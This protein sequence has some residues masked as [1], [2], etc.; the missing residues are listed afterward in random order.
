MTTVA[1]RID[2]VDAVYHSPHGVTVEEIY[3]NGDDAGDIESVAPIVKR[4][5]ICHRCFFTNKFE[6]DLLRNISCFW[7]ILPR[8]VTSKQCLK[9]QVNNLG[10]RGTVA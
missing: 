4:W 1:Y 10:H 5:S 8:A 7:T 2:Q 9:Q 6:V 3:G